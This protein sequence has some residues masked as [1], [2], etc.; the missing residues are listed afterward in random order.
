MQENQTL[1]KKQINLLFL[2]GCAILIP[3]VG[4]SIRLAIDQLLYP[5]LIITLL[6]TIILFIIIIKCSRSVYSRQYKTINTEES[7]L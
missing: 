6:I 7:I 2:I 5:Q 1:N 3:A 4:G